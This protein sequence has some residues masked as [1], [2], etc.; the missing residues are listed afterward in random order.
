[1]SDLGSGEYPS[2]TR[3]LTSR[4]RR[5]AEGAGPSWVIVVAIVLIAAAIAVYFA[6]LR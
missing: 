3:Q 6:A 2:E 5:I 1:M 4:D